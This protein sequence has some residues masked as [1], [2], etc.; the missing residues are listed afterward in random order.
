[1]KANATSKRSGTVSVTARF[2]SAFTLIELLVVIAI[3][4]ILAGMLLPAL[5][6]AKVKAQAIMCMNNTKQLMLANG[7]YQSDNA[8]N[9][10][11]AFHG[12]YTPGANDVNKPWVT[13]WLDWTTST[14]NTNLD[15]LLQ[16]QYAILAQ[17]FGK[18]KNIYLCPADKFASPAQR[19]RGWSSRVRSVSGN[20]YVGK[21]NGW[22]TGS[23][24]GPSGPYNLSPNNGY[25]GAAKMSQLAI[26]GPALTWVYVDENPDSI[27]DAGCFPSVSATT[28]T[29]APATYHNGAAGFAFADGHSEIHR[30]LGPTMRGRLSK[31]YYGGVDF[32]I[33]GNA[34]DKSDVQ[35]YSYHSPRA[36]TKTVVDP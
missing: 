25:R 10:P 33:T 34:K 30:W 9:F 1:M 12:G 27:N 36:T 13:G 3:I 6:K 19:T 23:W 26:P 16:P 2:V 35:W 22:A 18:Q 17:Y 5:S 28:F 14:Q 11:M 31:V 15:Y 20:I 8:D 4:A 32:S 29:D 24:G 7:M 21:G